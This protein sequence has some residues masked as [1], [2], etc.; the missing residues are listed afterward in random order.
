MIC[1]Q[2]H[3]VVA[4]VG[5]WRPE[6]FIHHL[7]VLPECQ[8]LGIAG[9]LV[10]ACVDRFSM[11]LSLKSLQANTRACRYYERN[12]WVAEGTGEGSEGAY[13]HYWLRSCGT[14]VDFSSG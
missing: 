9:M 2:A 8:G 4:F 3:R 5:V 13:N 7:Y 14:R 6:R 10:D 1:L 11:P 12:N